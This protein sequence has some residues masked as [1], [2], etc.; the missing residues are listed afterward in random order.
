M[1]MLTMPNCAEGQK[2][3]VKQVDSKACINLM[4]NLEKAAQ[5][6]TGLHI[7]H[8]LL[9]SELKAHACIQIACSF[10]LEASFLGTT[11]S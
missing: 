7:M 5:V 1:H 9:S 2:K 6:E 8:A 4:H 3:S 11:C 10:G